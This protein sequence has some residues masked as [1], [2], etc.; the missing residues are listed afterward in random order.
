[1]EG[2]RG[3]TRAVTVPEILGFV[4]SIRKSGVL[5]VRTRDEAF[6]IDLEQGSVVYA[7]GDK[8]PHGQLLG[9]ILV[10]QGALSQERLDRVV[11]SEAQNVD[12]LGEVLLRRGL[13]TREALCIALTYQVQGLFHRLFDAED[14]VFQ[15]DE[16]A[17]TPR[18]QD[19][20]LNVTTL[21][22]ESARSSDENL[23]PT[24]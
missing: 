12:F 4:A 13:V 5:R 18:T 22:L 24:G 10:A 16:G 15:F 20:H 23:R 19:I 3:H 1:M 6:R 21:L 8:P 17:H 14:A 2:L 7:Q 9:Q 11:E